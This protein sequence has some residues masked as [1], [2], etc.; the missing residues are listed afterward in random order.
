MNRIVLASS[1]VAVAL[2]GGCRNGTQASNTGAN[3]GSLAANAGG[4]SSAVFVNGD[5][6]ADAIGATPPTGWTT[7]DYLNATGV[8]GTTSAPPASFSALNLSGLGT[9]INETFVVGGATASQS[10]PDLGAAQPFHFPAY[11]LRSARV[12]YKAASAYGNN[13]NANVLRQSMTLGLGDIDPT[14]GQVHVRFAIAPVLENPA[15][16]YNQQP[17]YYVELLDVTRGT[18]LYTAFNV[19]GQAGVPWNTTTSIVTGNAVQWLNWELIDISPANAALSVGDQVQL[20][21]VG[22]GCSLGGHFGRVYVDGTGTS[23]PGPFVSASAPT[24]VVAGGT[25]TYTLHYANGGSTAAIGTSV[26]FTTPPQTTYASIGTL[27]SGVTCTTPTASTAGTI[28]CSIG[29]LAPGASDTFTITVNVS[30]SATGSIVAGN[31]TIGAV[32]A[33]TLLGSKVT[34]T[35]SGGVGAATADIVVT[36]TASVSS[37]TPGQAFTSGS[38]LYTITVTN[39]SA[40]DQL[41]SSLGKSFSLTDVMPAQLTGATWSCAVSNSGIAQVGTAT[42]CKDCSGGTCTTVTNA[43]GNISI[44]PRLGYNGGQIT[45]TVWG[46]IAGGASGTM[47]N[48]ATASSPS[49]I[50]DPNLTNNSATVSLPIGTPVALNLTKAGGN[51]N[52]TV[53]STPAG[54]NC[55]T[56]CGSASA[57][58]VSGQTVMLTA[59]PAAG[60]ATFTGWSGAGVPAGC[61]GSP[62]PLSCTVTMGNSA[63]AITATFAP[64]P[65]VGPAAALYAYSGS[66]QLTAIS[67]AFANQIVALVT[68]ANGTPKSGVTVTFTAQPA[69]NGATAALSGGTLTGAAC[70]SPSSGCR[71]A[72]TNGAGFA[73]VVATAN[74]TAGTYTVVPSVT[75]VSSSATFSLTNFGVPAS[76]TYVTGGNVTD[77]Q[78]TPINTA[79]ASPL[80]AVVKDAA[81]NV[82]PNAT[83]TYTTVPASGASATLNNG[84]T[85]S[86]TTVTDATDSSG[87]SSITATANGTIGAFTVTA[88]VGGVAAKATFNLQNVSSGPANVFIVSGSPQTTPLS[89]AFGNPLVA[90]VSDASGNALSGVTVTFCPPASGATSVLAGGSAASAGC[91]TVVTDASGLASGITATANATGG[92][93]NVT[94][95]VSGV[96]SPGNFVLTNDGGYAITVNA[97]S[98]QTTTV[99]AV[100]GTSLQVL[101]WDNTADAAVADGT[102]VTFV[103]PT[104]GAAAT[105]SGGSACSVP[106]S[107]CRTATTTAGIATI[108]ATANGTSG[109]YSVVAT[110]PNAP[111]AANFALGN[112]CTLS[113]QCSGVTPICDTGT[114]VCTACGAEAAG[115]C[116][117]KAAATAVCDSSGACYNCNADSQ[118]ASNTPICSQST[119][120]CAACTTDAQCSNKDAATPSCVAGAC[121]VAYTITASAGANGTISPTGPQTVLS[122]GSLAFTIAPSTGYHVLDVQ[123]DSVSVGAPTSYTFTNVTAAHTI[124]ATFAITQ[125]AITTSMD[126][127]GTGTISP[128]SPS[129][130]YGADQAFTITPAAGSTLTAVTVDG[131]AAAVASPYTFHTVTAT[132]TIKATFTL[133]TFAIT[134]SMDGTGT[135]TIS[136]TSPTVNY[137]ADQAFTITPAAGSTLTAVTVDGSAAAVASPYTFHTVTAT[138]TIKAT[139]TLQTFAITTSMDGNGTGTISPTSPTVNYGADQAFTITAAAGSTLTAVT[140]D[141]SAAAVASPYTFHTVTA[142]HTIKATFTLQTFAITTSMDGTGAGTISPTSPAVNYGADQAFTI[143]ANAN[144]TLTAVTVDGSAAAVASPYTFHTVTATH[145]IKATFTLKTFAITTSMDG[146]GSGTISPTSPTVNYGADQAFTIT[147]ATGSTLTAVT[148]D[149][150]AAA[151]ASPYTFHTVTA[152][153]TIKATFTLQT[154]AITTSMDGNGSGTISPTSPTVNYGA[155]QAFTI[156]AAT[157]STLTA[158][159]VDGS[160]AAVA[161]PYTFHTV[162]ATHTIKATFT[163]QTF[164]ITSS[165]DGTGNG[166]GT[167]SPSGVTSVNY[168]ASQTFNF[169]PASSSVVSAVTVD[170]SPV[171]LA[172]SYSFNNVRATHTISVKFALKTFTITASAG[173]HGSISPPGATSVNDGSSQTFTITPASGYMVNDVTVDNASVGAVTTYTFTNVTATHT[174]SV[175]FVIQTFTITPSSDGTGSGTIAPG[176]QQT[177]SS[178]GSQQFTISPAANSTFSALAVDGSA[179]TVQSPYTFSNVTASHTIKATFTKKTFT[180]TP[181][182]DGT[183]NGT[184]TVS[185]ATAQTVNYGDNQTFTFTPDA[186]STVSAVTM[187]GSPVATANS[188]PFTNVTGSHTISVKFAL[189]TFAITV[190]AGTNGTITPGTTQTV[191]YG[192]SQSFTIAAS[193]GYHIVDVLV[194]G[195]SAGAITSYSFTNVT[196]THSISATF[197]ITC[198]SDSDCSSGNYCDTTLT[199]HACVPKKD[200]GACTANDQCSSNACTDGVCCNR[201]CNGQCEAC[202]V[203]GHSGT[204]TT[205]TSGEPHGA[206]TSCTGNGTLCGGSCTG[207]SATAC[208]YPGS[209][210]QCIAASCTNGVATSEAGCAGDGTCPAITTNSCGTYTCEADGGTACNSACTSDT[211]CSTGNWCN[212]SNKCVPKEPN[213]PANTCTANDQCVS[214][215]CTDGFCCDTACNGQC[216]ACDVAGS[217]GTCSPTPANGAPHGIRAACATDGSDCGGACDGTRVLACAYPGSDTQCR[218]A[219]C[220]AG[221]ATLAAGCN[222][223][224]ACPSVQTE[225]CSPYVCGANACTGNCHSDTDC[226]SGDWCSGGVCVPKLNPGQ[227]CSATDQC[228]SGFCVD[229]VCCDTTCNGQCEACAES[230]HEGTCSPVAGAPRAGRNACAT[231]GT[232]CGGACDA[233]HTSACAYPGSSTSCRGASCTDGTAILAA[234]CN[235]AGACPPEQDISCG[236]FACGSTICNGDCTID[237]DCATGNYCAAGIC[238]P[239]SA[240]GSVCSAADQ[241]AS[242]NCVDGVCCDTACTDQCAACDVPGHVGTCSPVL[243]GAAPEGA[244]QACASDGTSCGGACD[245]TTTASCAYPDTSCRG[246]SCT[247]GVATL[248]AACDGHGSCPPVQ[249]QSCGAFICGANAC[250]GNCQSNSDCAAGNFCSAGVCTATLSNG[251]ACSAASQCTSGSCVDGVCCNTACDGQCEACDVATHVG[252][253]SA[254]TGDPHGSRT[255]CATD[256]TACGGACDGT[257]ATG[258][259][260]PT[261]STQCRAASCAD[262]VTTSSSSCVGTGACPAASQNTCGIYACEG[263]TCATSCTSN[264]ECAAGST[265]V[266]Q[267]CVLDGTPGVWTVAGSG[268]C[269]SGGAG[270]L[271]PLLGLAIFA[272]LQFMRRNARKSALVAVLLVLAAP[273]GAFAQSTVPTDTSLVIDRFQPGA[274]VY[275][276]LGVGSAE[277]PDHLAFHLSAFIDYANQPLRLIANG[278]PSQQ[279]L[280]LRYQSMLYLG[281]SIGLFDRFELGFVLPTLIA[282]KSGSTE[283]LGPTLTSAGSGVGDIRFVPKAKLYGGKRL[284]FAVALPFTLPTGSGHAYLSQGRATFSPELRLETNQNW[285]PFQLMA[286]AGVALRNTRVL[287]DLNLSNAFTWGGA[288]QVP[289]HLSTQKFAALA[290]IAGELGLSVNHP[291]ERPMEAMGALRWFTPASV[292]VTLGAGP[293]ITNG[294]G[295]PRFRLFGGLAYNPAK[296]QPAAPEKPAFCLLAADTYLRTPAGQ[297]IDVPINAMA[298]SGQPITVSRT[299]PPSHGAV[300]KAAS[301]AL[302]YLPADG[303]SGKDEFALIVSDGSERTARQKVVVDVLPPPPPPPPAPVAELPLPPMPMPEPLPPP[304][305]PPPAANEPERIIRNGHIALLAPVQFA[306]D[307]DIILRKSM[308]ILD[309]VAQILRENPDYKKV[310]IEGHTDSQGAAE[311]NLDLSQRRANSVMR[312]LIKDKIDAARLEA[313]GFGQDKPIESNASPKGRARNRRVEFVVTDG[314]MPDTKPSA[315]PAKPAPSDAAKPAPSDAAKPAPSDSAKPAP[316]DA[317]KPAPSDA[318]AASPKKTH[319]KPAPKTAP[320]D[321]SQDLPLDALPSLPPLPSSK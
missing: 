66:G 137:G 83:V 121:V 110:T 211:D 61:T 91:R 300:Q 162:T 321:A 18:T 291:S 105:L 314:P 28:S 124:S 101:V 208:T 78:I 299:E 184:G 297:A 122:G 128:T 238:T 205:L 73:S 9:S 65:A 232:D 140:V 141:G 63:A 29:T 181:S 210:T 262:G 45:I 119:N 225:T 311:H 56:A 46:T 13:K 12:N 6:E 267:R 138:H 203:Q 16:A 134:T 164:N 143:T 313:H 67:T 100:F 15:H 191:N 296:A 278:Q 146:N 182:I 161:S 117:A 48:T 226:V 112:N 22:S 304:P 84:I 129:V 53:I 194:D 227:L 241:C 82:V 80:V 25:I 85:T 186:S 142:T 123:V 312:Y 221:T 170:G 230:G 316:S 243:T 231:D 236:G 154:F 31:Y 127:T 196:G 159:T 172:A 259:A 70:V 163:L 75:S 176:T 193:S 33:V 320:A 158:V 180:L 89:T 165:V 2:L 173:P 289:F 50:I 183:G 218:G 280:L 306:V 106:S 260:Y 136:P 209:G 263:T 14:D 126:G 248:S 152:T 219:S 212:G 206:R 319:K 287:G 197:A 76:I 21:I 174:I 271:L 310:S 281:A 175:T 269:A 77:P 111:G 285:L 317:A 49:G 90:V 108:T 118:C 223:A 153:H 207:A 188:Y 150:S 151:V 99:S 20:T 36:K 103:G 51:A 68:D 233:V 3:P 40:T 246:A 192:A 273:M 54:I 27:P 189:K 214:G 74:A 4:R 199:P 23:I 272:L 168:D 228:G 113:S 284:V 155:D 171:A 220:A 160:A 303:Y 38:P 62:A 258:C 94:A 71:T 32:N 135:G 255:A 144:S 169:S 93:Y 265:C 256:G 109:S 294:Y 268:G 64:A 222:G 239:K 276:L 79:F 279:V 116:A 247:S 295:T 301:G 179:V 10:D 24:S 315:T 190:S 245:G 216:Q 224:G 234:G 97:G 266:A 235:S 81:G 131:S 307:K 52:G 37:V 148:V 305:P 115:A 139:F 302:Q 185:P 39:N 11:G 286:N 42:K 229:G 195:S 57:N 254:V 264:A 47:V 178:G 35:V 96:A 86:T 298:Q 30:G 242:G 293:G 41:R 282:Q 167:I 55:G 308:P 147:P 309:K 104:S 58:F 149:G 60:G 125:F 132:H 156:T 157:G 252:T 257:N 26:N 292:D 69:N 253:C 133:Q 318:A 274:G 215:H 204:C 261:N 283:V 88:A 44:N 87:M 200:T 102:V 198:A 244:R 249:T 95:T 237:S 145:T 98:P 19:A 1:L 166:T 275:D 187:D 213:S 270:N 72:V 114:H 290:T 240:P 288:A 251:G 107:G 34:T 201:A 17:F 177:V 250:N 217:E 130:N 277:T 120:T 7:L 92:T 59:S 5:M 8:S 43:T 202:D